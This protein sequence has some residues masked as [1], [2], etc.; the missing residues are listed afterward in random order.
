LSA[1]LLKLVS[2]TGGD[3]DQNFAI[4]VFQGLLI[5][6]KK[7]LSETVCKNKLLEK[8]KKAIVWYFSPYF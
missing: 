4:N 7:P 3:S 5:E 1:Q 6:V 8:K 2:I